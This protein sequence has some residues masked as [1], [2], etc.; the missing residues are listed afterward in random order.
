MKLDGEMLPRQPIVVKGEVVLLRAANKDAFMD[1]QGHLGRLAPSIGDDQADL[2]GLRG[3]EVLLELHGIAKADLAVYF[4]DAL[5][6]ANHP[7]HHQ[8]DD[9]DGDDQEQPP[10]VEEEADEEAF[11]R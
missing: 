4:D 5:V 8:Q 6:L 2:I 10:E 9:Q 1:I 7:E 11:Y 3:R